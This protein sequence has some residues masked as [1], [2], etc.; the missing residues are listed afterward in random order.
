MFEKLVVL[1]LI[2]KKNPFNNFI[3]FAVEF[4]LK[5]VRIIHASDGRSALGVTSQRVVN[6]LDYQTKLIERG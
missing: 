2:F 1:Q 6:P 4:R 5:K 3:L